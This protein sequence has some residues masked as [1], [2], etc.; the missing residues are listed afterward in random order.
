MKHLLWAICLSLCLPSSALAQDVILHVDINHPAADDANDGSAN[1][2]LLSIQEAANRALDNKFADLSTHVW[3]HPGTYRESI[4]LLRYTNWPTNWPNLLAPMTFEAITPGTAIVSGADP[5]TDWTFDA[6]SGAYTASWPYDWGLGPPAFMWAPPPLRNRAN[7]QVDDIVRRREILFIDDV[8]QRQVL[9]LGELTPGTYYV[10]E[11]ADLIYLNPPAGTDMATADIE[12]GVREKLWL[13]EYEHYV[14]VRGLVFERAA[15]RW[16][17][18]VATVR[19]SG[20]NHMRLEDVDIRWNNGTGF[21]VGDTDTAIVRNVRMN[22]NGWDGWSSWHVRDFL[23]EYT[24]TNYNNWRGDWGGLHGDLVGNKLFTVHGLIIRNHK[25]IGNLSRGLWLDYDNIGVTLDSLLITDNLSDGLDLEANQGPI[26]ITNSEICN[27]GG[28]GLFA[29]NSEKGILDNNVICNNASGQI[30]ATGETFGR[31]VPNWETGIS[32]E[33]FLLNWELQNNTF[34][35][36]GLGN[37]FSTTLSS[38][39]WDDFISS[40][41]IDHNTWCHITRTDVYRVEGAVLVDFP[42]WQAITGQEAHSVF[43]CGPE[44]AT[45]VDTK[46][47]LSGPYTTSALDTTLQELGHLPPNQPYA[48]PPWNYPGTENITAPEHVVDWV[49]VSLR[50][51]PTAPSTIA[52]RAALLLNDGSIVDLDNQSPVAFDGVPPGDYYVVIQHRNH[53]GVMS[54]GQVALDTASARYDFTTAATQAYGPSPMHP[55]PDG[56]FALWAGDGDGNGQ[57]TAFDILQVWHPQNG[58]NG[59]LDGDFNLNGQVTAFDMLQYWLVSNG[60]SSQV[61]GE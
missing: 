5:W 7:I 29:A 43:S 26:H 15:T 17:D 53:L 13:Q 30:N 56:S 57:V 46:I 58:T 36:S 39:G 48:N 49:L 20:S 3:I 45:V 41:A 11:A 6:G 51:D 34:S 14:T 38:S 54:A 59:Y 31:F 37:L 1:F 50:T 40:L 35:G 27:N 2:P 8:H 18:A 42:G 32:R 61:P 44:P 16:E 19:F 24:E 22:D 21:Y 47:Y 9:S 52:T 10:D 23:A 28:F 60:R 12:A 25:A 4:E 33:L 55:L